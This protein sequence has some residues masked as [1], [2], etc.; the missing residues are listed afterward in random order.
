VDL[1]STGP[2]LEAG[3]APLKDGGRSGIVECQDGSSIVEAFEIDTG[4]VQTGF[5]SVDVPGD[6]GTCDRVL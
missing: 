5:E 4:T 2:G 1:R 6:R 3:D